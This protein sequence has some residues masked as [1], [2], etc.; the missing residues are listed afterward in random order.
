MSRRAYGLKAWIIQRLTAL[1]LAGYFLFL[2]NHFIFDAPQNHAQWQ[3]WITNPWVTN[4][5]TLFCFSLLVH[6]WVGVRDVLMDYV[7]PISLRLLAMAVVGAVLVT[8]GLWFIR[9]LMHS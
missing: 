3:A 4:F 8:S 5:A 2:A 1:Y 6:A 9:I 7:K